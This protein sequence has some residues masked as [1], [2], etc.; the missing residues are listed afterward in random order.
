MTVAEKS[1]S[2]E[3]CFDVEE[4]RQLGVGWE[5]RKRGTRVLEGSHWNEPCTVNTTH[6]HFC[7]SGPDAFFL[8]VRLS[9]TKPDASTSPADT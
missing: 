2:G 4:T 7:S 6:S 8:W 5:G 3:K 1:G 9:K